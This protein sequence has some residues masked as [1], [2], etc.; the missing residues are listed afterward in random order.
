[1]AVAQETVGNQQ[2]HVEQTQAFV[3]TGIQPDINLATVQTALANAKVQLVTARNNYAVAE[4]QLSQAMGVSVSAHYALS[5]AE[6]SAIG[7]EDGDPAPLVA[8]AEKNRPELANLANQRR[9]QQL[10]V[11]SLKGG[12]GP[13]LSAIGNLSDTGTQFNALTPNWYVGLGLTW[14]IFQGG[15]TRGQ[16]REANGTLENIAGQEQAMRLQVQVDVE[17]GRLGVQAAK[18]T[19]GAADE[20]LVN[21]RSQLTLA[22]KRYEHGLGSAVE[23]GDAQVAYTSAEAQVV[24]AKFNLAAARAQLLAALGDQ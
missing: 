6:L 2:K 8:H 3:R 18:A 15:L 13:S 14:N 23:L 16:V 10:T 9:A 21:A 17:Q 12:Y 4:A 20:A 22:E 1:M 24:Q 19:I 11:T 5:D 7:G